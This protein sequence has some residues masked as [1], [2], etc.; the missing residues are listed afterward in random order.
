MTTHGAAAGSARRAKDKHPERYCSHPNCLW[1]FDADDGNGVV[2]PGVR[3][4]PKHFTWW[5]DYHPS[6]TYASTSKYRSD[7]NGCVERDPDY[8]S[9]RGFD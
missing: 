6:T 4:C 5:S 8:Y 2:K 7:G 3:Y 1:R 9:P